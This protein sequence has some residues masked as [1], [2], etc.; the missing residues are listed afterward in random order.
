MKRYLIVGL[1]NF[2]STVAARLY[3]L[4][5][6]VVIVDLD[7][8]AVDRAGSYATFAMHGDG[9][10]REVLEQCH[11]QSADAAVISTGDDIAASTL[12]LLAVRDLGIE[13]IYVKVISDEHKRIAVAVGASETV[14]PEREAAE[15]LASRITSGKLL[16]YVQYSEDF[17]IQEMA[18]P[19][20]W[21]GQALRQLALRPKHGVQVVAIHDMLTDEIAVPDPDKPLK[22]S[23]ALLVAGSSEALKGLL[24]ER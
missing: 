20:S 16:H 24:K 10:S 8:D 3:A 21:C 5:H 1:G 13:Q 17:G 2:G 19:D 7:A 11:A 14:F 4:G 12:A 18:V 9:A 15:G 6:E 23:D 22:S